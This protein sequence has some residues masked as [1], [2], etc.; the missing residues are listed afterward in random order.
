MNILLDAAT[1]AVIVLAAVIGCKRG[2]LKTVLGM[3]TV[4]V[5]LIALI[6]IA[7]PLG[8]SISEKVVSP[9]IADSIIKKSESKAD[10]VIENVKD[11]NLLK[12][13]LFDKLVNSNGD[14]ILQTERMKNAG[15]TLKEFLVK[16]LSDN[17]MLTTLCVLLTA[18][19]MII[20]IKF[21][22][23]LIVKIINPVRKI[24]V[25]R[26]FDGFMGLIIGLVNAV[27]ILG[28]LVAAVNYSSSLY[29]P[30]EEKG[31]FES[32]VV[33]KTALYKYVSEYHPISLLKTEGGK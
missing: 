23:W 1:V 18:L 24:G 29:T 28:I 33:E 20:V 26:K 15:A 8:R 31:S 12:H 17:L 16:T 13:K 2:F 4:L 14:G 11:E 21:L 19:L 10:E 6:V 3:L 27:L 5:M 32:E 22:S 7:D 30:K 9:Y 25:V